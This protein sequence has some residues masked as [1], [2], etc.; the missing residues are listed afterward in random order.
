MT[1]KEFYEW[2]YNGDADFEAIEDLGGGT[3]AVYFHSIDDEE[4]QEE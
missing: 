1:R 4:E 2:I 3:F